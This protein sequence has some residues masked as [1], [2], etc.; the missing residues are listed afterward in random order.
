M[1]IYD[2]KNPD[3]EW[4]RDYGIVSNR[5]KE[6]L[7]PLYDSNFHKVFDITNNNRIRYR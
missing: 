7:F 2:N 4:S 6:K 3:S 5:S 1:A